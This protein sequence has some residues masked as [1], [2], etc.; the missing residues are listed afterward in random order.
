MLRWPLFGLST[1]KVL[2]V[3][4]VSG[5]PNSGWLKTLKASRRNWKRTLSVKTNDLFRDMSKVGADGCRR[6]PSLKGMVRS[7]LFARSAHAGF[8]HA[9]CTRE[10]AEFVTNWRLVPFNWRT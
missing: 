4:F 10:P 2:L 5:L 9:C 3:G 8:E 1:P 7:V 6:F